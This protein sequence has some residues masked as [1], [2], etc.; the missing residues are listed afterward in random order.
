MQM[1]PLMSSPKNKSMMHEPM[2]KIG[3]QILYQNSNNQPEP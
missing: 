1:M 3:N 2:I